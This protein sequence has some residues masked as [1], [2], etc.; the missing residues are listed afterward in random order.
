MKDPADGK[1]LYERHSICMSNFFRNQQKGP[2]MQCR[3]SNQ[4]EVCIGIS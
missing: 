2:P 3:K 1:I 4:S